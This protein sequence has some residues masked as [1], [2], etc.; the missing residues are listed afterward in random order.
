M[1]SGTARTP[2]ERVT[3]LSAL[4]V[5]ICYIMQGYIDLGFGTWGSVF[6]VAA[7][8][9]LVGKMCVA[10]GAWGRAAVPRPVLVA[11]LPEVVPRPAGA[12]PSTPPPLEGT[13]RL[14]SRGWP[15]RGSGPTP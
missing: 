12:Q 1:P 14:L 7:S 8:Y 6:A 13:V 10:N 9:A 11:P 3:A 2:E 5:Q 15:T 4:A